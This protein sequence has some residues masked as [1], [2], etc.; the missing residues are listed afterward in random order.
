MQC[1]KPEI[2]ALASDQIVVYMSSFHSRSFNILASQNVYGSV[3]EICNFMTHFSSP[4]FE[5]TKCDG[6]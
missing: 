2:S 6:K 5:I 1:Q 4:K 3:P